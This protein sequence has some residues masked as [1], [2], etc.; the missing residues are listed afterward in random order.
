MKKTLL[1]TALVAAAASAQADTKLYG[2][3]AYQ[4]TFGED[5]SNVNLDEDYDFGRYAFSESRYGIYSSKK[6]GSITWLANIEMG[7]NDGGGSDKTAGDNANGRSDIRRQV[8]GIKGGFGKFQF[9]YHGDVGD[10]VLHADLAGTG[11]IDPM[12]SSSAGVAGG[13]TPVVTNELTGDDEKGDAIGVN[14][15]DPDEAESIQYFSPKLGGVATVG[16][17]IEKN[18]AFEGVLKVNAAGF[19]FHAFYNDKG[20]VSGDDAET[21]VGI[22]VGYKAPFGLSITG[23]VSQRDFVDGDDGEHA[24]VKI[25]YAIGKHKLS[26]KYQTLETNDTDD[27]TLLSEN[28]ETNESVIAWGYSPA[29]GVNLFAAYKTAEVDGGEDGDAFGIGGRV[30]F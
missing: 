9:G 18:E 2:Q 29:K 15:Y 5:S 28:T 11:F 25:G 14:G 27:V 8:F 7:L 19:R 26:Y 30:K 24:A 13:I 12:S 3:V 6:V 4:A 1:A 23:V 21:D 22:L 17:Q 10:G 16:F 20:D